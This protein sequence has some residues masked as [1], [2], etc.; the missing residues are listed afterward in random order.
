MI[1]Q[2]NR[3]EN[4]IKPKKW[5]GNPHWSLDAIRNKRHQSSQCPID[6]EIQIEEVCAAFEH[7][8]DTIIS[9]DSSR[10]IRTINHP[11]AGLIIRK[12]IGTDVIDYIG[13]QYQGMVRKMIDGVFATGVPGTYEIKDGGSDKTISCYETRLTRFGGDNSTHRV[14][15]ITRDITRQK[16]LEKRTRQHN[17]AE[18][19]SCMAGAIAHQYNNM[20]A[21]ILGNLDL[22]LEN[23]PVDSKHTYVIWQAML[24]ANRGS[25]LGRLILAS[26]GQAACR[27][28]LLDLA[29]VCHHNIPS[30]K[31][32][33]AKN[34]ILE[35]S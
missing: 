17:K 9:V 30:L 13:H 31:A 23:L 25:K 18:S 4:S 1:S 27:Y 32:D 21:V 20:L 28:E 26:L 22:A 7:T 19:L 29:E 14:L 11:P 3:S 15:L 16:E 33:I 12:M 10:R 5:Q 6:S 8:L 24:A 34:V 35:V 2:K